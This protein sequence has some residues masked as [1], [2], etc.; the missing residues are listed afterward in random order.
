MM[1][2]VYEAG[3]ATAAEVRERLA[4]PPSYSAVRATLSILES[5]GH[6]RHEKDGPRYVFLPTLTRERASLSAADRVLR[7]FFGGSVESA[8]AALLEISHD[9]LSEAD[10]ARL[11]K[12]IEAAESRER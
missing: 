5:K 12:L 4:D 1:D 6:L 7:T 2:I 8:I 3:R 11:R 9:E 10:Y